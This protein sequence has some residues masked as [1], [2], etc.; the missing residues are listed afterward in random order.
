MKFLLTTLLTITLLLILTSIAFAQGAPG[1]P[2]F[3]DAPS[4]APID[5][6]LS[7]LAAAGGAYAIKKLRDKR[8]NEID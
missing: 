3:P 5:G 6:G 4:A 2:G 1:L 8:T 7:L